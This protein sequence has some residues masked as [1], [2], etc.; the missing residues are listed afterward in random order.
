MSDYEFTPKSTEYKVVGGLVLLLP[1]YRPCRFPCRPSSDPGTTGPVSRAPVETR[2]KWVP[3]VSEDRI[4]SVRKVQRDLG[5]D[6][7][8]VTSSTD[9]YTT[10]KL[11]TV[12]P[13]GRGLSRVHFER[14]TTSKKAR[15]VTTDVRKLLRP[16][17]LPSCT[18]STPYHLRTRLG[19]DRAHPPSLPTTPSAPDTSSSFLVEASSLGQAPLV[20]SVQTTPRF[21][22]IL[23]TRVITRFPTVLFSS[24]S[25]LFAEVSG[26]ELQGIPPRSGW[27]KDWVLH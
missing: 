10:P 2:N 4:N 19:K 27:G 6:Y 23:V 20:E 21:R 18:R 14:E 8:V 16:W 26:E 1:V 7:V 5:S 25:Y 9:G 11:F 24:F 3:P 22:R 12:F 17:V 13:E 15:S